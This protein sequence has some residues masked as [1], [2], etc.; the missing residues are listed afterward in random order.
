[1]ELS[2]WTEP[3]TAWLLANEPRAADLERIRR[4]AAQLAKQPTIA[5]VVDDV[6][7][8]AGEA[9]ASVEQQVYSR[10]RLI[11]TSAAHPLGDQ[12]SR[13]NAALAQSGDDVIAFCGPTQILA[14]DATFEIA[15]A[16]NEHP[17]ADVVY[18]DRDQ[19]SP[20]GRRS[21]PSFLPSWSPE[22]FLSQMY[23]GSLIFYRRGLVQELGGFRAGF[24][25][26]LHYD[27]AL[28][29]TEKTEQIAHRSCVLHHEMVP[30]ATLP[31]PEQDDVVLALSSALERRG[32]PGRIE[33]AHS[34]PASFAIRY[35]IVRPGTVDILIPTR[36]LADDL[37]RCL[38]SIFC[39]TTYHDF[40]VTVIDNR[41]NEPKTAQTLSA[42]QKREPS[43]FRV[44]R[45]DEDFNFSRL[46][47]AGCRSTRAPYLLLL[48]N[49]TEVLAKD[50]LESMV[51]QAQ[52]PTIGAVGARL[53]FDDGRVQHAGIVISPPGLPCHIYRFAPADDAG[54]DAAILSTRNYS[55]LTA[56]CLMVR[57]EVFESV[58]GFDEA[59]AFDYN[60]VDFCLR[61]V[62]Q[63][64]RN[65][66]LPHVKLRH[67]E[68]KTRGLHD[69]PKSRAR[70]LLEQRLFEQRW[71]DFTHGDSYGGSSIHMT[72]GDYF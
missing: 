1:M 10:V 11:R 18:G 38:E 41:S 66:Y 69:N 20:D 12:V 52:R 4:I 53:L 32:E 3:H 14:P 71:T 6:L 13:L 59:F 34:N 68:S 30:Q 27:L 55:A 46:I 19:V 15:L 49:D 31:L 28:R 33:L 50:W 40:C 64:Y 47:N 61:A 42:W 60:D 24:G 65:V 56:A 58:G 48:N 35:T 26:A 39:L 57:R 70:L 8:N 16:F 21:A 17:D 45:D 72:G 37:D 22:T 7:P 44:I 67:F 5:I 29:I 51:E 62:Q 2:A 23:T 63:G 36:D 43:R 9:I 54:P 25:T